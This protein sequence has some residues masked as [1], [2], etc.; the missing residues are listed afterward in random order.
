MHIASK[1]ELRQSDS[2]VHVLHEQLSLPRP[3]DIDAVSCLLQQV[4]L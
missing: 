4:S 3:E 1:A 2:K